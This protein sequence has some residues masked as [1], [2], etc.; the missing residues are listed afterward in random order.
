[1]HF[2]ISALTEHKW[3]TAGTTKQDTRLHQVFYAYIKWTLTICKFAYDMRPVIAHLL[4]TNA[5]CASPDSWLSTMWAISICVQSQAAGDVAP[6]ISVQ[7]TDGRHRDQ[8]TVTWQVPTPN[9]CKLCPTTQPHPS[10]AHI[11]LLLSLTRPETRK[12]T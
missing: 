10:A 4:G 6:F 11:E 2:S 9:V 1:M 3:M 8:E 5:F 12:S 7:R